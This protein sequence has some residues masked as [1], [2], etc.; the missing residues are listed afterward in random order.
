MRTA[1]SRRLPN[2]A[3][4][5]GSGFKGRFGQAEVRLC[6]GDRLILYTDGLT[7]NFGPDG[8]RD[9]RRRFMAALRHQTGQRVDDLVAAVMQQSRSLRENV[10]PTDDISQLAIEYTG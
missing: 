1:P 4:V 3:T 2:T 6:P 10:P 5:I 7:D 9:G 8:E